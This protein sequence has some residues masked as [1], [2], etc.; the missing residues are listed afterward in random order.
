LGEVGEFGAL[1]R[2]ETLILTE[3]ILRAGYDT[4][5]PTATE[6]ALPPYLVPDGPPWTPDYPRPFRD[7]LAALAGYTFHPGGT[8]HERGH[9]AQTARHRYD[10]HNAPG[11]RGR[12]LTT[13]SRDP[14]GHDTRIGYD[15]FGMLPV[16]TIDAAGLRVQVTNDYRVFQPRLVT[17]LNDN[18]TAFAFTPL[19]WLEAIAVM[20]KQGAAEGDTPQA[21]GTRLSYDLLG[22]TGTTQN[23]R[24]VSVR[25]I[26]RVHHVNE[27]GVPAPERDETIETVEYSDGFGRLVQTRTRAED[28][29]VGD[30]V[31]G[32]AVLPTEQ[33][34][35]DTSK[36]FSGQRNGDAQRPNVV[37]SGWRSY[38]NKGRVI[39]QFE[40]FFAA[41]WDYEPPREV[42]IGQRRTTFYDPR[43]QVV[44]TVD[45]DGSEQRVVY[46]VPADLADP[47]VFQPTPWEAYTYD[48]NDN[49]GRT[50]PARAAQYRH[51][52]D[53]PASIVVDALGRTVIG[54]ERTRAAPAGGEPATVEEICTRS[55]YDI[56]GNLVEFT[57]ALG[58]PAFRYVY[59]L[60]DRPL[61]TASIDAG[62]RR[63]V[64]DAAGNPIEQRDAKGALVL[65]AYDVLNRPTRLWARD[66][67][68][69]PMT[70]RE[71]LE[72]GDGGDPDQAAA[73]RAASRATN[74]LGELHRHH[75]EA[76]LLTFAS[77]DVKGNLLDRSRQVISDDA[78]LPMFP[79]DADP[80]PD[81]RVSAFRVDW[82]PP[83][84]ASL[85][86]LETSLLDATRYQSNARYDALNRTVLAVYPR[87]VD[88]WRRE[89]RASYDRA[90]NLE[91][92]RVDGK[93]FVNQLAYDAKGQRTLIALGSGVMTRYAYHPG[94]FRLL[95]LR[96]ERYTTQPSVPL[97]YQPT[98]SPLQDLAYQ[99]D[100]AGNVLSV[101]DR[102]PGCGVQANPEAAGIDDPGLRALVAAGDALVRRFSY[103]PRYRLTS[104]SGR[105]CR[106][107]GH[108][109]PW[110]DPARCGFNSASHA[111]PNQDNAPSLTATY[112]ETYDY[113]PAGN[114]LRLR[115]A[116][117][118]ATFVRSFAPEE[119]SNRLAA[120][121]AG[122]ASFSYR[123]DP[124]GNTIG[125]TASRHFEWDHNNRMKTFRTQAGTSEPSVHAHYLYDAGGERVKKLVRTQGGGLAVT[126]YLEGG[127]EHH[128][129]HRLAGQTG[130]NNILHVTDDQDRFAQV[131]IGPPHPDD[132][133]PQVQYQ[134]G[135]HLS[136][137]TVVTD[138]AGDFVNREEFNPYGE[139]SFGGFARKR[140]RFTGRERDSESGLNHHGARYYAPALGR[141]LSADPVPA[142]DGTSQFAYAS[143]NPLRLTDV[144]GTQ[145]HPAEVPPSMRGR[146]RGRPHLRPQVC[147]EDGSVGPPD[148]VSVS[149]RKPRLG[150]PTA[151]VGRAGAHTEFFRVDLTPREKAILEGRAPVKPGED[152]WSHE[153]EARDRARYLREVQEWLAA[154]PDEQAR[155]QDEQDSATTA[156]EDGGAPRTAGGRTQQRR[157]GDRR[158]ANPGG[159]VA[160]PDVYVISLFRRWITGSVTEKDR[161]WAREVANRLRHRGPVDVGHARGHETVFTPP[162][163]RVMIMPE[164][165][166]PNR[167]HGAKL[168]PEVRRV[169]RSPHLRI[170]VRPPRARR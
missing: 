24:P 64:Q 56:R 134:L 70:L 102:T 133:G 142:L 113:D 156:G 57:D 41:G 165:R 74:R 159:Q 65:R 107:G 131:R 111:T 120:L 115:R 27:A 55:A 110:L 117:G 73:L 121:T 108:L 12:G 125:E 166:G 98:G 83:A 25:T 150:P 90:S 105:E 59:D 79:A 8:N 82:E 146:S 170:Y 21:P 38:D 16:E 153:A 92:I 136:S 13:A 99:H 148:S 163:S 91:Q 112:R 167:S 93:P 2:T 9:F 140:Y 7:R 42:Q 81:W 31:F 36:P 11:G 127:F 54:V 58:R 71:R 88:G 129:W 158:P 28:L 155:H 10:F 19:G 76:G 106:D 138:A 84:G 149:V 78:I 52:W 15:R 6:P 168:R 29:I 132:R 169:R 87:D 114:L 33:D 147:H 30:P 53:T 85:P 72:Y 128:R 154:R 4:G 80:P 47:A 122:A 5:E 139:S 145:E 20:G 103:D 119:G 39:E 63:T 35:P 101:V 44:R 152:F 32:G 157:P 60:A 160:E 89:L 109:E 61:R 116:G 23:V 86:V 104:A 135:D 130:E 97:T 123:H 45:P 161:Q 126:T 18:Q 14:L 124:S 77:Y 50:H 75:D 67:H 40:P 69:G 144:E 141:W 3:E 95:R 34:D 137:S 22:F 62:V 51:H 94:T 49:A 143:A 96:S 100:L 118:A 162:G 46:G 164:P 37:V 151:K 68:T 43:G 26:R 17:D 48:A 66:D 1:V